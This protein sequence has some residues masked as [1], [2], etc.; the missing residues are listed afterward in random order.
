M[1]VA[2]DGAGVVVVVVGADVV[3]EVVMGADVV[4]VVSCPL[5]LWK[6]ATQVSILDRCADNHALFS[7]IISRA[8]TI[9]LLSIGVTS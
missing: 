2:E 7:A 4:V 3:L 5:D 1:L 8:R 9:V 6:S